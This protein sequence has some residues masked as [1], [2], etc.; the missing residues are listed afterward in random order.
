MSGSEHEA[1]RVGVGLN[2]SDSKGLRHSATPE[3]GRSPW[4]RP[5]RASGDS[6]GASV[7]PLGEA[8]WG[9]ASGFGGSLGAEGSKCQFELPLLGPSCGPVWA[10]L[11]RLGRLLGRLVA[12]LG[13]FGTI[14]EASWA[15]LERSEDERN[16]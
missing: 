1:V 14:L 12:L 8:R 15:V 6:S 2:T 9:L 5:F 10:L 4:V 13:R 7:G 11:G 16:T 3:E